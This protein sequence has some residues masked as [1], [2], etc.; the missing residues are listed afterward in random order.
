MVNN[1]NAFSSSIPMPRRRKGKKEFI[2]KIKKMYSS[3]DALYREL[4]QN[5]DDAK[6]SEA[7]IHFTSQNE[8]VENI[9]F[10]NNGAHFSAYDWI[11]L[12]KIA[13]E[14]V[15]EQDEDLFGAGTC[16]IF[17][18]SN[19]PR[20]ASGKQKLE[21]FWENDML[22]TKMDCVDGPTSKWTNFSLPSR[23]LYHIPDLVQL[24]ELI[25]ANLTFTFHLSKVSVVVNNTERLVIRKSMIQEPIVLKTGKSLLPKSSIW[26]KKNNVATSSLDGLFLLA[27]P[28]QG[29]KEMEY[30]FSS[31]LDR[32]KGYVI[33]RF[34]TAVT[35]TRI[36][37]GKSK[38][39]ERI[40]KK[41]PQSSFLLQL[42]THIV[43][44]STEL[45]SKISKIM[46]PLSPLKGGGRIFAGFRTSQTTGLGVHVMA[47]FIPTVEREAIN[48]QNPF[49]RQYNTDLLEFCG[50]VTRLYLEHNM[51]LL[52]SEIYRDQIEKGLLE[53]NSIHKSS[54][55]G[56]VDIMK[57]GLMK[58]TSNDSTDDVDSD[59]FTASDSQELST[60]ETQAL[61][62]MQAFCPK[63]SKP[64]PDVGTLLLKGFTRC[65]ADEAP[66]VL[67]LSGF[68]RGNEAALPS[69]G[70]ES[71]V[72][73]NV[74]RLVI[75]ESAKD[76]FLNSRCRYLNLDDLSTAVTREILQEN[77]MVLFMKWWAKFS[78][79]GTQD[80]LSS[81]MDHIRFQVPSSNHEGGHV[82]YAGD[83]SFYVDSDSPMANENLPLP[84]SVIPKCL[85]EKLGLATLKQSSLRPWF[86]PL[87]VE[88]W[89]KFIGRHQCMTD[90]KPEDEYLR[91]QVLRTLSKEFCRRKS[92]DQSVFGSICNS[93]LAEQ[94][95][96]PFDSSE[97]SMHTTEMPYKLYSYS[98]EVRPFYEIGSFLKASYS[99]EGAGVSE[100]FL[101]ALGVQRSV[102]LRFLFSRLDYLRWSDDP[103]ILVEYLLASKL[104]DSDWKILRTARYLPCENDMSS[105]RF[106]PS[107]LCLPDPELRIFPFVRL[108]QWVSEE[109]ISTTSPVGIFLLKSGVQCLPPLES[110]LEYISNEVTDE[111]I[112]M[113][114]LDFVCS[115]I[116]PKSIYDIEYSSLSV[117][118]RQEYRILPAFTE[119]F[120]GFEKENRELLSPPTCF[121]DLG[122]A[123]MG[124]SIID[125]RLG[126]K[127]AWY[128]SKLE[129][130]SGPSPEVLVEKL[131]DIVKRH[132]EI[133]EAV[134]YEDL[135]S[136][137]EQT[138]QSFSSIFKYLSNRTS[139]FTSD[140]LSPLI[141]ERFIPI[142][143]KGNIQWFCPKQVFF[144]SNDR[145]NSAAKQLFDTIVD[146]SPF[147][148]LVGVQEEVPLEYLFSNRDQLQRSDDPRSLID[149]LLTS[150]LDES[151]W[152]VLRTNKYLPAENELLSTRF[153][154]SELYMPDP[155]LHIFRFIRFL[156]WPSEGTIAD[157]SSQIS[158][159]TKIGVRSVPPLTAI[160]KYLSDDVKD[161]KVRMQC[162]DF[163]CNRLQGN[164]PYQY[165]YSCLK[166]MHQFR[167]LPSV[168][169]SIFG[170]EKEVSELRSPKDCFLERDSAIMGF[171]IVDPKLGE[172]GD[173]YG[174]LLGCPLAP[175][176]ELLIQQLLILVNTSKERLNETHNEALKEK[177][178][179]VIR[180]FT[181]IFK[182]LSSC[183][184]IF[185]PEMLTVLEDEKFIP[186]LIDD[187]VQWN[188]PKNVFFKSDK[189][190]KKSVAE[191]MFQTTVCFSP[192]LSSVGVRKEVS[193][194]YLASQWDNLKSP[195]NPKALI[196]YLL[197]SNTTGNTNF[198]SHT[199]KTEPSTE[200][201]GIRHEGNES[202]RD[203][204]RNKSRRGNELKEV[205]KHKELP[206]TMIDNSTAAHDKTIAELSKEI[207]SLKTS[208]AKLSSEVDV[209]QGML[210]AEKTKCKTE[211]D[212]LEAISSIVGIL[213][214]EVKEANA[215][216]SKSNEKKFEFENM[217]DNLKTDMRRKEEILENKTSECE[218]L[219]KINANLTIER[220][221]AVDS[222][223][224]SNAD[225]NFATK[226]KFQKEELEKEISL[227]L[228]IKE[229][230]QKQFFMDTEEEKDIDWQN[231]QNAS[232]E[233]ER[234]GGV[235][236]ILM[237]R[238]SVGKIPKML[239]G[240][241]KETEIVGNVL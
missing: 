183:T 193:L 91:L 6:A 191:Q 188:Y 199:D 34:V 116:N 75:Y 167:I 234:N 200:T 13:V 55:H 196:D 2:G 121:L 145:R 78:S 102:S 119:S 32:E 22:H 48:L 25:C 203:D 109:T 64:D 98:A 204:E 129:C 115:K 49:L 12:K 214:H 93:V 231:T 177:S 176:S 68:V 224:S 208:E 238:T 211:K 47:P 105:K 14:N 163:V 86:S 187:C 18:I 146:F 153:M 189:E 171:S 147:L 43:E 113:R 166:E 8:A 150:S 106:M 53:N 19:A 237:G 54:M 99:L 217:V 23:D 207:L 138:L 17:R 30:K 151:D 28:K 7:E 141:D 63:R 132:K 21:F 240:K 60:P 61:L 57:T 26:K 95:C 96:I 126:E 84:E 197:T 225:I 35:K 205:T 20:I 123:V 206:K 140:L 233:K 67:T 31:Q 24:G 226:L 107:D 39:I 81:L 172:K 162:L 94:R 210:D 15:A 173:L 137:S 148:A 27:N 156:K 220:N 62:L 154:P 74:V 101:L 182:Y 122:C 158:F 51:M 227:L 179:M 157:K 83:L 209:L 90:G 152:E 37:Y 230:N 235:R 192:F 10:S 135:N 117:S 128:G 239:A 103:K 111:R 29:I 85:Q 77:K 87:P 46:Q 178:E 127:R 58:A 50:I 184:P 33:A 89:V 130:S 241:K 42:L 100:D 9:L 16:A 168:S 40:T 160:L 175:D 120:L 104:N 59:P 5:S 223:R 11:R 79:A 139:E 218:K 201:H 56:L 69:D 125:P 169:K 82:R 161:D 88:I 221:K 44:D 71:L 1:N 165:E 236:S 97:P 38:D 134:K 133:P 112:R 92:E 52:E 110:V 114:C 45:G 124:F 190:G 194:D 219:L 222:L 73:K 131:L 155:E 159:L 3:N 41:K 181:T 195:E 228:R 76:F 216:L 70:I 232:R 213:K 215:A 164:H 80:R 198:L 142:A 170:G 144:E 212:A 4:L 36:P 143:I 180:V 118:N 174:S 66:P 229:Q 186:C 72:R 185:A 202:I 65:I 108:L 136:N 149:Y